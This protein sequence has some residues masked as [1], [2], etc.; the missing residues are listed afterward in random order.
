MTV[1]HPH[2]SMSDHEMGVS[3]DIS[4]SEDEENELFVDDDDDDE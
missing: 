1:Q 2:D 4:G 3:F